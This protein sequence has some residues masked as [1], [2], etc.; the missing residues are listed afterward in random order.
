MLERG[1]PEYP[2]K[3]LSEQRREPTTNSTHIWLEMINKVSISAFAQVLSSGFLRFRA[4]GPLNFLE[5]S[6]GCLSFA[7]IFN[8]F[9]FYL[10]L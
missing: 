2:G 8:H 9:L 10:S 3:N 4:C 7:V 5:H 6:L 1:K